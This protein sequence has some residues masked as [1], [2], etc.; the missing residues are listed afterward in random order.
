MKRGVKYYLLKYKY[1][2]TIVIFAVLIGFVGENSLL[3]RYEQKKEIS[4]LENEIEDY[5]RKFN[6]DKEALDRLKNDPDAIEEVA[7]EKYYMKMADE[8]VFIFEDND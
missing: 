3:N 2:I 6:Q 7:R 4:R 8:D 1:L 5:N